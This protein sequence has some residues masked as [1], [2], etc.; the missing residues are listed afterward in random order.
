LSDVGQSIA[1]IGL[2]PRLVLVARLLRQKITDPQTNGQELEGGDYAWWNIILYCAS[3][4]LQ[5][6]VAQF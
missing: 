6:N 2:P 5:K 3:Q 4:T 1:S